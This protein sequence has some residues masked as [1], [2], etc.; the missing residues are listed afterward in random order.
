MDA[1]LAID[2]RFEKLCSEK[3]ALRAMAES[4]ADQH[5]HLL[6]EQHIFNALVYICFCSSIKLG[7]RMSLN[8][9]FAHLLDSTVIQVVE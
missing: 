7:Q 8:V 1:F 6:N 2:V 9:S 4:L 3:I 5:G